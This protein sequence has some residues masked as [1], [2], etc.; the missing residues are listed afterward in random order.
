V[1]RSRRLSNYAM[2]PTTLSA[3]S[4]VISEVSFQE[5]KYIVSGVLGAGVLVRGRIWYS[6]QTF[7][8]G[9]VEG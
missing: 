7:L 8:P 4:E 6:W 9:R 3:C 5:R 2:C 1:G